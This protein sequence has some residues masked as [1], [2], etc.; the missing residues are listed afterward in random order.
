MSED[1]VEFRW[2][3]PVKRLWSAEEPALEAPPATQSACTN[4][5]VPHQLQTQ[6]CWAA[7]SLGVAS[8]HNAATAWTQCSIVNA[9]LNQQ[10]C[11]QNGTT[12]N[13]NKPWYLNLAL[14]RVNHLNTYQGGSLPFAT[15]QAEINAGNPPC[16]LIK[17]QAT[18]RGHFVAIRCWYT[19]RVIPND[20]W[21]LI[22]DPW[23]GQST[24]EYSK[25][26]SAY[27]GGAW[28]FWYK[29]KP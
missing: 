16:A 13:C 8:M 3:F 5:A 9:E 17:W 12:A 2:G 15:V 4:I 25:F 22:D 29:T 23:Y 19:S 14:K 1:L 26:V 18:N 11:C 20:Q 28:R 24:I 6:W 27:H 10:A 7:V 21:L